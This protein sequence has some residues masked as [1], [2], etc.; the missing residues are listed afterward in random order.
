MYALLKKSIVSELLFKL[1]RFICKVA[2]SDL[3]RNIW[4]ERA[5]HTCLNIYY[6]YY[7]NKYVCMY[8]VILKK[9]AKLMYSGKKHC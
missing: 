3:F 8:V 5:K 2:I 7:F 4:L 6:I 1:K 9:K